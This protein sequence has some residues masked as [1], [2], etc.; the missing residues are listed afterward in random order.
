MAFSYFRGV[1]NKQHRKTTTTKNLQYK[2]NDTMTYA[3]FVCVY[4]LTIS[5]KTNQTLFQ[6]H[7]SEIMYGM[8]HRKWEDHHKLS[9]YL[10][11]YF[12]FKLL[13]DH[14]RLWD[15]QI[16]ES[17]ISSRILHLFGMTPEIISAII[18]GPSNYS[19]KN[20]LARSWFVPASP[21]WSPDR[22]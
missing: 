12:R 22:N 17:P 6:K 4:D 16:P 18:L 14:R 21:Q 7:V 13:L 8:K 9:D 15:H 2:N 5:I 10:R 11:P 3:T 20:D 19:R 1:R